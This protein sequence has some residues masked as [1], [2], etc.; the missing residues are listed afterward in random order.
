MDSVQW[1]HPIMIICKKSGQLHA[2]TN[3]REALDMLLQYWPVSE[4]KA[5][6]GALEICA[7]VADGR[8]TKE[9]ARQAFIDAAHEAKVPV[10]TPDVIGMSASPSVTL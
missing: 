2:V 3:T 10:E 9:Q 1:V 6:F 7:G 5:F 4:G 8:A